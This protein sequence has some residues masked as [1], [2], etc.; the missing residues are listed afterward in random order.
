MYDNHLIM[1]V[2]GYLDNIAPAEVIHSTNSGTTLASSEA[3]SL[4]YFM[5]YGV[6]HSPV[7]GNFWLLSRIL[8]SNLNAHVNISDSFEVY[9]NRTRVYSR[10]ANGGWPKEEW[11]R[12]SI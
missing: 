9:I 8:L 1:K 2:L 6:F 4:I 3:L 12:N 10:L 5:F 11:V 7:W